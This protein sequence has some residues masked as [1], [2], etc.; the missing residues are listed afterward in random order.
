[1]ARC[2]LCIVI[3]IL[4]SL[5][6]NTFVCEAC[7]GCSSWFASTLLSIM[8]STEPS[9]APSVSHKPSLSNLNLQVALYYNA[10]FSVLFAIVIG[11]CSIEKV[12]FTLKHT[13]LLS[14]TIEWVAP[15]YH[16]DNR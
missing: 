14:V 16:D 1:M 3:F 4:L 15:R 2:G 5:V 8:S 6:I 13:S 11:A 10:L 7:N 12:R 9:G